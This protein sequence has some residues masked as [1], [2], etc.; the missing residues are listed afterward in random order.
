MYWSL[1]ELGDMVAMPSQS[2]LIQ[3]RYILKTWLFLYIASQV[4]KNVFLH[5]RCT[6]D[7]AD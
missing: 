3:Y 5:I 4:Q 1:G 7:K 6:M 2:S